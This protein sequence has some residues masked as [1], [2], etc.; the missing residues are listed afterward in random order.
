MD[1]SSTSTTL[2]S[3]PYSES[4]SSSA[5]TSATVNKNHHHQ[6]NAKAP[7][8]RPKG[9]QQFLVVNDKNYGN[10][11]VPV[12]DSEGSQSNDSTISTPSTTPPLLPSPSIRSPEGSSSSSSSISSSN[13]TVTTSTLVDNS[14]SYATSLTSTTTTMTT[15]SLQQPS[16]LSTPT[17]IKNHHFNSPN[18]NNQHQH[19]H[20]QHHH[21]QQQQQQYSALPPPPTPSIPPPSHIQYHCMYQ[22]VN[23]CFP[24]IV[25]EMLV[26][27]QTNINNGLPGTK[28]IVKSLK[29]D[30]DTKHARRITMEEASSL[31]SDPLYCG[32]KRVLLIPNRKG[33]ANITL[34][35]GRVY[36]SFEILLKA[37]AIELTKDQP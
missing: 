21:H 26:V 4:S 22:P 14:R 5:S 20:Q 35:I 7:E 16:S 2:S 13:S 6:L 10:Q 19:Q 17:P 30:P 11:V 24:P 15:I 31:V 23:N 9:I 37:Y 28:K 1:Q 3:P 32:A 18:Y 8:F 34:P 25:Q 27:V 36:P 29:K 12:Y 33:I